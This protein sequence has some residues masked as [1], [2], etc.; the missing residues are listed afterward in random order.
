M[1]ELDK[2]FLQMITDA[3]MMRHGEY[4][5][6]VCIAHNQLEIHAGDLQELRALE[7]LKKKEDE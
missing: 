2:V 6:T 5:A 4:P 3:Y 7:Y 1:D